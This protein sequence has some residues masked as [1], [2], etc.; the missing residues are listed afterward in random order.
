MEKRFQVEERAVTNK[1]EVW[2]VSSLISK[3]G[4]VAAAERGWGA[5]K[6]GNQRVTF[7]AD[8]MGLVP[9]PIA[10]T[11]TVTPR[12]TGVSGEF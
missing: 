1:V 6:R 5:N 4:R 12:Q 2:L 8:G 3:V 9:I 7:Q 11:W 10:S